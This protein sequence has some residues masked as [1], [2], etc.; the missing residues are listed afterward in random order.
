M[1]KPITVTLPHKL[2]KLEAK[3]RI[4]DGIDRIAPQLASL[5]SITAGDWQE[6][7]MRFHVKA[8][9]QEVTGRIEVHEDQV[10]VEVMLPWF[11]HAIA[12]KLR[13]QIQKNTTQILIEKK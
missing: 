10:V 7:E 12:E 8:L 11:L 5:G 6:D 1:K 4:R 3:K 2:S 9:A 13:G